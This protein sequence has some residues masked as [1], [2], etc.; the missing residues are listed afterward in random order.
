MV[1]GPVFT[2]LLVIERHVCSGVVV[3]VGG[4]FEL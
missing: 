3:R 4:L 2:A 1:A